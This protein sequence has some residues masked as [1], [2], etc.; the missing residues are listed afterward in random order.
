MFPIDFTSVGQEF[1]VLRIGPEKSNQLAMVSWARV[2]ES[3]KQ[4]YKIAPFEPFKNHGGR[5][6]ENNG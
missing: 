2:W 5:N 1:L 4:M 3:R 6:Q